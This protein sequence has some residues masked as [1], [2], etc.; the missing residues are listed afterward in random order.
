MIPKKPIGEPSFQQYNITKSENSSSLDFAE[1]V[2]ERLVKLRDEKKKIKPVIT[3]AY[4]L[5]IEF[6]NG[7]KIYH[8]YDPKKGNG[9]KVISRERFLVEMSELPY[10]FIHETDDQ[11]I[12]EAKVNE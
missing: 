8:Y 1:S 11:T 6:V 7:K 4:Q 10:Y 3:Y 2:K 12:F 5:L 9:W